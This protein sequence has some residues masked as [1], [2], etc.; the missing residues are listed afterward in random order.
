[1]HRQDDSSSDINGFVDHQIG[2][3]AKLTF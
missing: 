3:Q 1:M 2:I